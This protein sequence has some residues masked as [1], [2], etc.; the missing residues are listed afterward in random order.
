MGIDDTDLL[1]YVDGHLPQPRRAEVEAAVA[2]SPGV[3]AR[4]NAM[5]ASALP[6]ATAFDAQLLPPL[7][8]ELGQRVGDLLSAYAQRGQRRASSWP[9]LGVAFAAGALCCAIALKLL[10]SAVPPQAAAAQVSPWIKAVAD[11]QQLYSRA[12]LTSVTEDPA[13]SARVIN[14]LRV[15]DGIA[16]VVPDLRSVALTFKRVQRL[17]FHDRPVVQMVYLPEH[18]EP[19]AL[20]VTPDA[21]PDETPHAQQIGEMTSVAWHRNNLGYVVLSKGPAR[22]LLDLGRRIA[23]GDAK[24]LYGRSSTPPVRQA[25]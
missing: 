20:C 23:S 25:A 21:R 4:L 18:G 16:V 14:D 17:S 24:R 5:R 12:T 15:N 7:P 22:T 19:I 2:S 3:A 9:R 10:P 1:A 11:Y 13:L 8:P 6:Y